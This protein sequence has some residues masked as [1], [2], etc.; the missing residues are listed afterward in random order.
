MVAK[1]TQPEL[2]WRLG[3]LDFQWKH[4]YN[5]VIKKTNVA[6]ESAPFGFVIP[7]SLD[8]RQNSSPGHFYP[9]R[10]IFIR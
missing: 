8:R 7:P 1:G 3:I 10:S 4:I 2:V 6:K 9:H 5:F